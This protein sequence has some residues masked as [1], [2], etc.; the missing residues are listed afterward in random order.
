MSGYHIKQGLLMLVGFIIGVVAYAQV[1]PMM[2]WVKSCTREQF[3]ATLKSYGILGI[4]LWVLA[5]VCIMPQPL[6]WLI[7]G[8]LGCYIGRKLAG[9]PPSQ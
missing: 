6:P 4:P 9:D 2:D 7:F 5:V 8:G 1:V 3:E